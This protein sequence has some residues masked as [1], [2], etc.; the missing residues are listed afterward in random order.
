MA[1]I[2]IIDDD[3]NMAEMVEIA[4]RTEGHETRAFSD[5]ESALGA[6]DSMRPEAMIVDIM[7]PGRD[8]LDFVS[9]V[10]A[11]SRVP[12]VFMTGRAQM[13]DKIRGYRVGGDDYVVKPFLLT[14]L[15]LRVDSLLRR[16]AWAAR[17]PDT[18]SVG[19]LI[20]NVADGT[21]QRGCRSLKLTRDEFDIVSA[22]AS[23]PGKPWSPESLA[24]RLGIPTDS[25]RHMAESI[26]VKMSR[27]RAKIAHP[28]EAVLL[29]TRRGSGY[30]ISAE[31]D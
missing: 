16:D 3:P 13:R 20:L 26:Y 23:T 7:L 27:L 2:L 11:N 5:A 4:L 22:L 21:A 15:A 6:I 12:I 29:H 14:E 30:T 9:T 8:G 18:L 17:P 25:P 24:R 1:R 28:G 10:R 19:D 31:A